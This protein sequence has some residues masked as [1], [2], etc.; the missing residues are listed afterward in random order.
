MSQNDEDD[1]R[2]ER[3]LERLSR[4]QADHEAKALEELAASQENEDDGCIAPG[5]PPR[6]LYWHPWYRDRTELLD[7]L[8]SSDYSPRIIPIPTAPRAVF[9]D[10]AEETYPTRPPSWTQLRLTKQRAFGLAPYVG[11]PFGYAW[12][13]ASDELGR[14]I[15][16]EARIVYRYGFPLY[17]GADG[18]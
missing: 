17:G 4:L 11:E 15:A 8:N 2:F 7:W 16:G 14:S 12:Y 3:A 18:D 13:V 10:I 1:E 6:P 5:G 9:W